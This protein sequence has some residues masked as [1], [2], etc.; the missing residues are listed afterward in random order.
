MGI[1]AVGAQG[2]AATS[3][4]GLSQRDHD[5]QVS[6]FVN[7]LSAK[8]K[9]QLVD[10]ARGLDRS[11][12]GFQLL[13]SMDAAA[14]RILTPAQ[15]RQWNLV[16]DPTAT[17]PGAVVGGE[18]KRWKCEIDS[19]VAL[20]FSVIGVIGCPGDTAYAGCYAAFEAAVYADQCFISSA[21]TCPDAVD[22]AMQSAIYWSQLAGS[23][24]LSDVTM[25][26]SGVT[27][28]SCGGTVE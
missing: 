3:S 21:E 4:P 25:R 6:A 15:L 26:T 13:S 1:M 28:A 24:S 2:Q 18:Y 8:Q 22:A 20:T 17:N 12:D 19:K 9:A 14:A 27:Y 11:M 23:C 10:A 5:R 16:T 7:K